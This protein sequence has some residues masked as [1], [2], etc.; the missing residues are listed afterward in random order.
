ML[1]DSISYRESGYFTPLVTD[2]LDKKI[3][4]QLY[5]RFPTLENFEAQILQK[6][7][8]CTN[9]AR[10]VLGTVIKQQY[11]AIDA[12]ELTANNIE[13]LRGSSTF[14][15]TTGHQ[16]NL[17]TGPLYFLYKI[18]TTINL[19]RELAAKYPQYNFV[20]IYWMATEDHDFEE[21][22]YFNFKG[23]KFRWNAEST[24]P[25]GRLS[26]AGLKEFYEIYSLELGSSQNAEHIK[27]LFKAAYLEHE[28]LAEAT[29]YLANALF[30]AH[31]LVI[32][33][34]DDAALKQEFV[35]YI[36]EELLK[37]TAYN[38]VNETI[39]ALNNYAI[40]VN[41][42]EI[43]LFYIEDKLRERIIFE[44]GLYKIN[45]T[46]REFTEA[47]ILL[48]VEVH[49][50][51]FSPNVITRPLYQEVI[52]PNLCYV[53]GG[54]EI[55]YWLEL[56]SY[57][58]AEKVV[59]PILLLRNSALL[60]TK[61]QI[62]KAGRLNLSAK[63]LFKKQGDLLNE[64][65]KVL[66]EFPIDLEAQKEVL[67]KQF[68]YLK[69]IAQRTDPSFTGSVNAQEAKQIKGLIHLEKRLQKAQK[70]KY[71]DQL[72]RICELQND[73]FPNKS[74]QERQSNFSEFYIRQGDSL[75]AQL[76]GELNPLGQNFAVVEL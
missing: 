27:Q 45:N 67:R 25:V 9:D 32:V 76:I 1:S 71:A 34:G 24:G 4:S 31:G 12:S 74:L 42:R 70:R 5:N 17:F 41:P 38:K 33:D 39:K 40:Q 72:E 7:E 56:K 55:A 3:D 65:V 20:P 60:I 15:V 50:E 30:G 23:K 63:D 53:G 48:H 37:H 18:V 61:K 75:T 58:D 36:K 2:Y 62:E 44:K 10:E 26:T 66:S 19:T 57:F 28:T 64:K 52:L 46:A 73:L 69:N 13:A 14:S 51:R 59:F 29:R 21:I 47:E 35:P 16:L 49:P 22:N 68:A 8:N 6:K 54:G 11:K 43:N